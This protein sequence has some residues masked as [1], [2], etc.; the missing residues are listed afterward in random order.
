LKTGLILSLCLVS[1]AASLIGPVPAR[2]QRLGVEVARP[3]G[4]MGVPLER[5]FELPVESSKAEPFTYNILVILVEFSDVH[6][7]REAHP[8]V[9]YHR[10]FFEGS[11]G[12]PSLDDYY[13]ANS[14]GRFHVAG[15]VT[16][17]VRL[18]SSYA[19][20]TS[21]GVGNVGYGIDP[22]AYPHNAQRLVEE[23]VG[24]IR[25]LTTWD[26]FDNDRDG[27]VDGVFVIHAGPGVD[28][29]GMLVSANPQRILAHQYRTSYEIPAAGTRVFDYAIADEAARLGIIAHEFGHLLGLIDLYPAGASANGPFGLGDWSLM[30]TGALLNQGRTPA[31]LDA[32]SRYRLGFALPTVIDAS[33]TGQVVLFSPE[34]RQVLKLWGAGGETEYFLVEDRYQRGFDAYLPGQG[35]LIYHVDEKIQTNSSSLHPKVRIEQADGSRDLNRTEGNR[36]DL[37]DPFPNVLSG[38][39][40]D[41][42]D[43]N[44]S[45]G[46]GSYLGIPSHVALYNIRRRTGGYQAE[47][48]IDDPPAPRLAEFRIHEA[49]GD[50]DGY[51][52]RGETASVDVTVTNDGAPI[53]GGDLDF[54]F[55]PDE[56]AALESIEP[57]TSTLD[58][59]NLARGETR[60]VTDAFRFGFRDTSPDS[61]G[62][63][64][65]TTIF[66]FAAGEQPVIL[67]GSAAVSVGVPGSPFED[68]E[69][70]APGWTHYAI[71]PLLPD[72]WQVTTERFHSPGH[73]F[74]FRFEGRPYDGGLDAVL[75]TPDFQIP[76]GGRLSFWH[77]IDAETLGTGRA[78]D[79]GLVEVSVSGGPW[80]EI[81]PVGGYPFRL[82]T[83]SGNPLFERRVF[84]GH[85]AAFRRVILDLESL[86]GASARFR[87]RFASDLLGDAS[88]V[89]RG[90]FIDDV[91]LTGGEPGFSAGTVLLPEGV[92]VR[93]TLSELPPAVT[94]FDVLRR[95]PPETARPVVVGH[96]GVNGGSVEYSLTDAPP[97]GRYVY[98]VQAIEADGPGQR[99]VTPVVDVSDPSVRIRLAA[100][101]PAPYSASGPPAN[102]DFFVPQASAGTPVRLEIFDVQGRRIA[103]IRDGVAEAGMTHVQW[104]GDT[105]RGPVRSGIYF[106]RLI[107][108]GKAGPPRRL[109]VVS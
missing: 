81:E 36:G 28:E 25:D 55:T 62:T 82:E 78:W 41:E 68:F 38:L 14:D 72:P 16:N 95:D 88:Q 26:R 42:F 86:A 89:Q 17:W 19:Y 56:S 3:E 53:T 109:V 51:V 52:E 7:D 1:L 99:A 35:L 94:G 63:F 91:S 100:P 6:A 27:L 107:V 59:G 32:W 96:V 76:T 43:A 58:L 5:S 47:V 101:Y 24:K 93:W 33:P 40:R 8:P 97:P 98:E 103:T 60:F 74:A 92:E 87:F 73:S 77:S 105:E 44:T 80:R 54:V 18:D 67:T 75:V 70:G 71:N 45:P 20:Y 90:W 64:A 102:F 31:N 46:S 29:T 65:F 34:E 85:S 50:G 106:V 15:F 108:N 48:V 69:S 66:A 23:A 79:G 30:A 12:E 4:F 22:D 61:A 104:T 49:D 57:L 37:S 2:A 84:S 13:S 9:F 10:R 83:G 21:E 11:P 39:D